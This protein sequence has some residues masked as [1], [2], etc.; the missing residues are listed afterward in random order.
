M[1]D[2]DAYLMNKPTDTSAWYPT[3]DAMLAA[4]EDAA[5]GHRITVTVQIIATLIFL[6]IAAAL[7]I[8]YLEITP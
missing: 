7:F 4:L 3:T 2:W 1:T 6:G 5:L 8:L